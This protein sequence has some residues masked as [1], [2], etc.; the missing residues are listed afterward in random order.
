M[1]E[2]TKTIGRKECQVNS[3]LINILIRTKNR[4]DKFKR[5]IESVLNQTYTNVKIIV[6][7]NSTITSYVKWEHERILDNTPCIGFSYNLFCN[8]LKEKVNEGW[9]FFLDDDD[10]LNTP[11]ALEEIA[12]ELTNPNEAVICQF[13]RANGKPKPSDE[14]MDRGMI[15]SGRIGMPCIIL[16]SNHK[17][18]AQFT[19]TE[20]ADFLFIKE[21]SQKL[22]C[23]FVKKILVNSK[24]R[25]YG[26]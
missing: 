1:K 7:D 18:I 13:V 20:N 9:M 15:V 23:K 11:T 8:D 22:P 10:F 26:N 17:N 4:P 19:N 12:V 5:C 14:L 21:V 3:P 2:V 25:N 24:K 16:H 6:Y